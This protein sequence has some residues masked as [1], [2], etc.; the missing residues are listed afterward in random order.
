MGRNTKYTYEDKLQA[1]KDYLCGERSAA[2][3][4][5]RLQMGKR[6]EAKVLV[7]VRKYQV[8]GPD[9]LQEAKAN[10]TYTRE[11]KIQVVEEYLSGTGSLNDLVVKYGMRSA[12]QIR[13]W[14]SKYN[15]LE[16]L[17]DYDPHP[18]VYMAKRKKTTLQERKEIIKFCI[19]HNK[20]YKGTALKYDCSYSQVYQWVRKYEV[21]GTEGLKDKRGKRKKEEELSDLEK[22]QRRIKQLEYELLKKERENELLKKAD[23]FERRWLQD[24]QKPDGSQ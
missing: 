11:F 1:C 17:R 20:D 10:N 9:A 8:N 14:I 24:F 6:G 4:A 21:N 18:E 22:A 19:D 23:E 3:I 7:W 16:E 13:R 15:S 2:E 12:E 5:R